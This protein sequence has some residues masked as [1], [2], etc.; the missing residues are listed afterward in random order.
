M[1]NSWKRETTVIY[2]TPI[3]FLSLGHSPRSFKNLMPPTNKTFTNPRKAGKLLNEFHANA[4][5]STSTCSST[6]CNLV[7]TILR[8]T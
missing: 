6:S 8:G 7:Q 3:H 5:I 2:I 4:E 1:L